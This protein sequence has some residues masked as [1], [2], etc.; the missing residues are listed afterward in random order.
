MCAAPV[1]IPAQ[2]GT[3]LPDDPPKAPVN[4]WMALEMGPRFRGD[5]EKGWAG[6]Q[7]RRLS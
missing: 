4:W 3:H 7:F 1:V 5:D 6:L 2:A